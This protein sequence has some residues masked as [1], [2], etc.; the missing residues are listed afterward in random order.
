M[1]YQSIGDRI[2]Y[3]LSIR[4]LSQKEFAKR[5]GITEATLSRYVSGTRMPKADMIISIC[6]EL[7]IS[8][9]WLLGMLG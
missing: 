3:L 6:N 7:G 5:L 4:K 8:A 9:D 1:L 2:K